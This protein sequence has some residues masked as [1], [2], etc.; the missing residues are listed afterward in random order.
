MTRL[1]LVELIG[2]TCAAVDRTP[3]QRSHRARIGAMRCTRHLGIRLLVALTLLAFPLASPSWADHEFFHGVDYTGLSLG[4]RATWFDPVDGNARWF[5]GAQARFHFSTVF[6]IEGSIDYRRNQFG[7]N[8]RVD[9]YP[10]Q[11]SLLAY[12]CR[13]CGSARF[14]SAAEGGTTR[15]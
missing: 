10:V 4:A 12:C 2:A 15:M 11:V 14:C 8:T 6:A 1:V 5:G 7:P 13:A 3:G 9:T